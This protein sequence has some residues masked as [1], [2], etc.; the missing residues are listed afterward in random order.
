MT[1]LIRTRT[2]T[3]TQRA[4]PVTPPRW[5]TLNIWPTRY[6]VCRSRLVVLAPGSSAADARRWRLAAESPWISVASATLVLVLTASTLGSTAAL[7]LAVTSSVS[8][9]LLVRRLTRRVRHGAR[10]LTICTGMT[11]DPLPSPSAD[12]LLWELVARLHSADE[13]LRAGRITGAQHELAW[14][15]AWELLPPRD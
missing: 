1:T 7:A 4:R 5:G 6:G 12:L 9:F 15:E 10:E 3:R 11:P 8:G 14:S 2:R 13:A